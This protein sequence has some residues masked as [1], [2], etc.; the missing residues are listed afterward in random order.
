LATL[1]N[2]GIPIEESARE[3][4]GRKRR[5]KKNNP[6]ALTTF[7]FDEAAA[8]QLGHR[9]LTPLGNSFLWE[10]AK[11]GL[12]K[13][14]KQLGTKH[15][16]LL[17][18][19][20]KVFYESTTGWSDYSKQSAI[21]ETLTTACEEKKETTIRYRSYAAKEEQS[22]NIH[23]YTLVTHGGTLYIVG[24]SCKDKE[25][26][27]W[28]LNR[29]VAAERLQKKFK[30]PAD[31]DIEAHRRKGFGVFVFNNK[32]VEKVRIKVGGVMARYVQEHHWHET[33][34]F[35]EQTDGSVIVQFEVAP[36]QELLIWILKLGRHAEVLEPKSL[37]REVATEIDAMQRRYKGKK[38]AKTK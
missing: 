19:L 36:T 38:R 23:P 26:R 24:F 2:A 14:R 9:V 28:K 16:H 29:L 34:Q 12:Q 3:A 17:D 6:I 20:L 18:E 13:I 33:Q 1:I 4:H 5:Y 8:L 10:A 35:E 31:F 22:Y 37:R 32:P 11:N 7:N 30:K 15:V 21:V 27:T 25:V